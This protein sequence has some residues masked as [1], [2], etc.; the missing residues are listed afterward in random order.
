MRIKWVE[1]SRIKRKQVTN[2]RNPN[3][4]TRRR[5]IFETLRTRWLH[6]KRSVE[7]W[8]RGQ[9]WHIAGLQPTK[10]KKQGQTKAVTKIAQVNFHREKATSTVIAGTSSRDNIAILLAQVYVPGA[11][12]SF[13]IFVQRRCS[14]ASLTGS[15]GKNSRYSRTP[16]YFLGDNI[17]VPPSL[18]WWSTERGARYHF[19]SA[20]IPTPVTKSGDTTTPSEKN[21]FLNLFSATS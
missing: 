13:R 15:W 8:S 12:S 21:T 16:A 5:D 14:C 1:K 2:K 4:P 11:D 18:D 3:W 7:Q 17:R 9:H 20:T 10:L 6:T 19:S